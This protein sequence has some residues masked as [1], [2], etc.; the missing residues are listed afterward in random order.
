[1]ICSKCKTQLPNDAISCPKCGAKFKTMPCPYCQNVIRASSAV[2]PKC[3]KPLKQ[4]AVRPANVSYAPAQ[5][6]ESKPTARFR[7]WKLVSGILSIVLSML[8]IFQSCAA[9]IVNTLSSNGEVSGSAGIIV[10]IML[11]AGGIVSIA[12]RNSTG[13][14]G[15]IS[16]IVMYGLGA[17]VGAVLAGTMFTDLY[18]WAAW[19]LA[20]AVLAVI[21]LIK[22]KSAQ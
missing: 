22:N 5:Y 2:C 1:M 4:P 20:C 11:L 21:S 18:I 17:L 3:G 16:L 13:I 15:N 8:V 12:V 7:I 10:A 6:M 19:C 14:G 9:G